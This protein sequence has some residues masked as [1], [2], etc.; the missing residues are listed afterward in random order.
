MNDQIVGA[1][2]I[3]LAKYDS[4]CMTSKNKYANAG[5]QYTENFADLASFDKNGKVVGNLQNTASPFDPAFANTD[6]VS[7][8][9][10]VEYTLNYLTTD[11]EFP[12]TLMIE[13]GQIDKR[14]HDNDIMGMIYALMEFD[15]AAAYVLDW[16][17]Q[18][19]DT[20]VIITADHESGGLKLAES[21]EALRNGLYT[22]DDHTAANVPLYLYG[23]TVTET[24]IDNVDIFTI[25][26]N[27][28]LGKDE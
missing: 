14:N 17:S 8:K 11:T 15:E 1:V 3:L 12:F 16:A 2:D 13:G 22:S 4:S 9:E 25:A 5:F 28:V 23:A 26:H 21:K 19:D 24:L 7:L 6:V 18:R 10:M 20:V 27:A